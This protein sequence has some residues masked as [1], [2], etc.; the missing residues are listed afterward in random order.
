MIA[1]TR[2]K[3]RALDRARRS[4]LPNSHA[5]KVVSQIRSEIVPV[6]DDLRKSA[7]EGGKDRADLE[8]RVLSAVRKIRLNL[9]SA[10]PLH[11]SEKRHSQ[12]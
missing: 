11:K 9:D 5:K 7:A 4:A 1:K 8:F 3:S 12:G 10:L 2:T 6:L